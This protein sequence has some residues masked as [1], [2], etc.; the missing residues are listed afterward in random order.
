LW[1]A[2]RRAF[3]FVRP[4]CTISGNV[5]PLHTSRSSDCA[6]GRVPAGRKS[7]VPAAL[8]LWRKLDIAPVDAV[9]R[10]LKLFVKNF[11]GTPLGLSPMRIV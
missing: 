9:D 11:D 7:G 10:R 2:Q 5:R 3:I 4:A 6:D 1:D 8:P